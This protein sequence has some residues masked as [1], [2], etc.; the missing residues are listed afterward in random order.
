[1]RQ[2]RSC[3]PRYFDFVHSKAKRFELDLYA[4]AS[5]GSCVADSRRRP[6]VLQLAKVRQRSLKYM[7]LA[8]LET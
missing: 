7:H 3:V 1:M 5:F 4:Q 2:H 6:T 8:A